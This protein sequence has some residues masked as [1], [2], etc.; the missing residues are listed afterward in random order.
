M[1]K[2]FSLWDETISQHIGD[3]FS[4]KNK[5]ENLERANIKKVKGAKQ[6]MKE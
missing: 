4:E 3:I 2:H 1:A 5:W 6:K